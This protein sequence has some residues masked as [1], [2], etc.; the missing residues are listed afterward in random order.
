[1]LRLYSVDPDPAMIAKIVYFAHDLA[2]PAVHRRVRMLVAGGAVV[3]PIGF[4]RSAE[5]PSAVEGLRPID[6]GRTA[7]GMLVKRM[8]S[9]AC[10]LV[11][12]T[13]IAHHV[14]GANVILAR[15]LEMLVLAVR[16]RR[17]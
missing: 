4:R 1:M 10:S 13:S 16:A 11:G 15:N 12:L 3:T 17:L 7:D 6:L 9:V 2:D 14:R 5:A 8:L